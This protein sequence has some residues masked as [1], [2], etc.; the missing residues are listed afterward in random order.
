MSSCRKNRTCTCTYPDG[1][2]ATQATYNNVTKKEAQ[3]NCVSQINSV[4]CT[5]K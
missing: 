1:T 3:N 4:T 5:V 2:I